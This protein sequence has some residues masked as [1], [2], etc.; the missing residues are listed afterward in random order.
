MRRLSLYLASTAAAA[1]ALGA[2]SGMSR[3][4]QSKMSFFLTS[5]NPGKGADFGGLAGADR[6]CQSLAAS[7][8]AGGRTWRAYLSTSAAAGSPAVNARDRIGNGPWLNAKGEQIASNVDGLHGPDNKLSKQT[9]LTEKGETI[10]GSGDAVT[11]HDILTGSSPDGRAVSDGKDNT[12]GNWT[13]GGEG[14]AIVG[15]HDRRGLDDSAPAKSWNSSHPTS[16]CS[17]DALKS[18]GGGGLMYCFAQ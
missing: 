9:A 11:L 17:L 16:G 15:H 13:K 2:C 12:C 4:P 18:T 3:A 6:Y 1:I 7:A 8:G 14:S 5:T 10:S